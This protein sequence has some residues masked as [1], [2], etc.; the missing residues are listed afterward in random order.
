MPAYAEGNATASVRCRRPKYHWAGLSPSYLVLDGVY[1]DSIVFSAQN[2]SDHFL[3]ILVFGCY[4][5]ELS[6]GQIF[7]VYGNFG[8]NDVF[9]FWCGEYRVP[10]QGVSD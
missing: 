6:Q 4:P 10:R 8:N 2:C 3:V 7:N 5:Q 9:V 1:V